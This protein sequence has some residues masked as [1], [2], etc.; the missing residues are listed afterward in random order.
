LRFI[1]PPE[2]IDHELTHENEAF[3]RVLVVSIPVDLVSWQPKI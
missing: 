3:V 2:P 1:P